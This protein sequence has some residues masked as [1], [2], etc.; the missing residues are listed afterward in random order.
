MDYLSFLTLRL[1]RCPGPSLTLTAG[2]IVLNPTP[3]SPR[4]SDHWAVT[5]RIHCFLDNDKAGME[6]VQNQEEYGL[7]IR[8]AA[9]IRRLQRPERLA[10]KQE[11]TI[12]TAA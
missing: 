10:G 5:E 1:E 8:D 12:R 2:H 7:R 4:Q 11:Q 9:H 6:A 3:T